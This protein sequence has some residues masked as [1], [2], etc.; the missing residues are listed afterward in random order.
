MLAR[1]ACQCTHWRI[2]LCRTHN[3]Y[4]MLE[5]EDSGIRC[6]GQYD[7]VRCKR[8]YAY[9]NSDLQDDNIIGL[10][11]W[12]A[13]CRVQFPVKVTADIFTIKSVCDC[14][15]GLDNSHV[16]TANPIMPQWSNPHCT[17]VWYLLLYLSS[18]MIRDYRIELNLVNAIYH[19]NW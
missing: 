11:Q 10:G 14:F 18:L 8:H 6:S 15:R 17:L 2:M 1:Q 13:N 5:F 9:K 3:R 19:G 7:Q 4:L 16:D 12:R